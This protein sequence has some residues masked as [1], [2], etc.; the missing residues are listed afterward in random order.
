M[1]RPMHRYLALGALVVLVA[2]VARSDD[3]ECDRQVP[4]G[5]VHIASEPWIKAILREH[6]T[7]SYACRRASA[8][9]TEPD[10]AFYGEQCRVLTEDFA[11]FRACYRAI[12]SALERCRSI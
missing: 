6:Q 1:P 5:C 12:H 3:G 4:E 11:P 10:A 2:L 7:M 9:D 8:A